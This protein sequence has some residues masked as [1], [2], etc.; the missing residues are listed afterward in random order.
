MIR[1]LLATH[2]N[3]LKYVVKH[4]PLSSHR[5]A[6]KGAM[7]VLAARKQGK[8]WEFHRELLKHYRDL[9]NEK[10][11]EIAKNL[12]LDM[13]Q[14]K[15]DLQSPASRELIRS[16]VENAMKIGVQ[17]TPSVFLNG[18]RIQNRK[19]SQLSKFIQQELNPS[20]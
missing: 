6:R 11:M 13:E 4:Y 15:K 16:D 1:Q 18:K 8:Y 19:L 7:A 10:I 3:D 12:G 20:N 9:N 14:F 2:P 5:F 17:G